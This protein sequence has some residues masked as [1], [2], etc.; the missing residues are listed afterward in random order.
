MAV[1]VI[2]IL[3]VLWAAVLLP[4]VLR[5]RSGGGGNGFGEFGSALG[6]LARRRPSDPGVMPLQPL[7]GPVA[8]AR[9]LGSR[10]LPGAMSPIQRRRRDVLVGLL[11]LAGLTFLMAMFAG[12][13][14]FWVLH[15]LADALL[16]GYVY[17]LLQVKGR[18][19]ERKRKVRPIVA[20]VPRHLHAVP[21]PV[22][23]GVPLGLRRTASY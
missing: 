15:V 9:T 18:S 3:A 23:L 12:S 11:G 17:L 1:V 10:P 19:Q 20:A 8:A 21:D 22:A 7:M 16:G 2:L 6:A 13:I 5:A 4:P 14:P